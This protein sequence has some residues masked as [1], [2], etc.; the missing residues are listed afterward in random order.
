MLMTLAVL[1]RLIP[2]NHVLDRGPDRPT[3]R[4][5]LAGVGSVR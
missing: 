2:I 1:T 4:G 3:E 5:N